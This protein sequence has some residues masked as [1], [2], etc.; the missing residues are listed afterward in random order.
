MDGWFDDCM[1]GISGFA[2]SL[3]LMGGLEW[4]GHGRLAV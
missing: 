1:D 2:P 4:M 3:F